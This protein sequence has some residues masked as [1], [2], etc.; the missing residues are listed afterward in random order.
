MSIK[1]YYC[2][3]FF[4]LGLHVRAQDNYLKSGDFQFMIDN[5]AR[6]CIHPGL[7]NYK[8]IAKYLW[9]RFK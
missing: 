4:L 5:Q 8:E 9:K 6:D 2:I 3:L 1:Y 7:G